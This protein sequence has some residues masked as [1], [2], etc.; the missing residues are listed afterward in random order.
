MIKEF[1][2]R[3]IVNGNKSTILLPLRWLI[4]L[5]FSAMIISAWIEADNW[6]IIMFGII[7]GISICLFLFSFI[8]AL[9]KNPD[10]LRSEKYTIQKMAIERG[11][12]GDDMI[13]QIKIETKEDLKLIEKESLK[14]ESDKDE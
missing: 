6:I 9:F 7:S 11:F 3:A 8:Y 12:F 4:G 14:L 2:N 13:G 10:Y 5:C 1:L